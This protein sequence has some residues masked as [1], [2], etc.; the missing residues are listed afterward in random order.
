MN[1]ISG[2]VDDDEPVYGNH[3]C[4]MLEQ[5]RDKI[6][7]S[8]RPQR[9]ACRPWDRRVAGDELKRVVDTRGEIRFVKLHTCDTRKYRP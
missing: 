6:A 4:R 5:P 1:G 3:P 7:R 8:C 2:G 9:T